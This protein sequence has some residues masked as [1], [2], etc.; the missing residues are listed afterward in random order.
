MN[1]EV[2]RR[3]LVHV[4]EQTIGAEELWRVN[5]HLRDC[6]GCR[7]EADAQIVVRR[8]LATRPQEQLPDRFAS[9]LA[10]RLDHEIGRPW[11]TLLDWRTWSI[12][13]MPAV[14]VLLLWAALTTRVTVRPQPTDVA[15]E[16][17]GWETRGGDVTTLLVRPDVS[18]G[19]LLV[20]LLS[21]EPKE[22]R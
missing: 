15:D 3:Y 21:S 6:A 5:A 1:C 14:A 7:R 2:A 20:D 10:R 22:Q 18:D 17:I 13:L 11:L 8:V 12:R 16:M 9:Q 19:S 4:A